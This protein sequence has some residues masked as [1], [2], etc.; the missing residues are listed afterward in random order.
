[1]STADENLISLEKYIQDLIWNCRNIDAKS[2]K[3][4]Q[5]NAL[6][7]LIDLWSWIVSHHIMPNP[8]S[9][10]KARCIDDYMCGWITPTPTIRKLFILLFGIYIAFFFNLIPNN[11]KAEVE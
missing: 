2:Q 3:A 1:M 5:L 4:G 10:S 11:F 6:E 7:T 9:S 8:I